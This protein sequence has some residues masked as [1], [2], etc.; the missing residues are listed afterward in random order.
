MQVVFQGGG[1]YQTV[2]RSY[3]PTR[4]LKAGQAL[5]AAVTADGKVLDKTAADAANVVSAGSAK[6]F[7]VAAS[8]IDASAAT[9]VAID[10]VV[11]CRMGVKAFNDANGA[12]AATAQMQDDLRFLNVILGGE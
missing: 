5:Y 10:V 7:G 8:D 11:A 3:A 1:F 12:D 4:A 2:K 9:S 6:L